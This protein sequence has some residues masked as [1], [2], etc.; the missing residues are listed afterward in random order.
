MVPFW[1]EASDKT[2]KDV[3]ERNPI[4]EREAIYRSTQK[5]PGYQ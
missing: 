5:P 3:E 2:F 1:I 4:D